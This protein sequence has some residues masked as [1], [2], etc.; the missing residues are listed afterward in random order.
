[1]AE[2]L[3]P[4]YIEDSVKTTF[5]PTLSDIK[6]PKL[7]ELSAGVELS[8]WI[9]VDGWKPT[10]TQN[11]VD[12]AREGVGTIGKIPGTIAWDNTQVQVI[13]NTNGG[14]DVPN[15]A[16]ETLKEGVEGYFVRRRGAAKT[17]SQPWAAGDK[18]TVFKATIA[19]KIP[20]AHAQN[21]RQESLIN[22]SIDPA[23]IG[24]ETAVVAA[25]E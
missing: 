23:S 7:A 20:I 11:F 25:S 19:K 5:V 16:V 12:D 4:A 8:Q 22:F 14:L 6:A 9:T 10:Q 17:A 24:D 3:A 21:A 18:V 1:M 2:T 13:D 15:L